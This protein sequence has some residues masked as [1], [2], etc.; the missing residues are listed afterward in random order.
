MRAIGYSR[1]STAEQASEGMSLEAQDARIR[2]WAVAHAAD[3]VD[4]VVDD[5]VSGTKALAD[6]PN[7]RRIA[8]L[9]DARR[10]EADAVVVIRLDRLG[11]NAAEQLALYRRFRAGRVGLVAVSQHIDLATPHG[12]AMAGVSAVFAE[13]ERDLIAQRTAEAIGELRSQGRRYGPVPFGWVDHEGQ[14][15]PDADEQEV[16]ERIRDL[17]GQGV[18]YNRVAATLNAEGVKTKHGGLWAAMSVRSVERTSAK[19]EQLQGAR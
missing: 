19:F 17:R 14:L 1:V 9:L 10:P 15:V 3:L 4:V 8:S 11:R 2:A 13:L 16:L 7:G 12:R 6:R 18:A 5:G